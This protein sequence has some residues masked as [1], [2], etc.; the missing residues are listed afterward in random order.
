MQPAKP[1]GVEDGILI[2]L[3]KFQSVEKPQAQILGSGAI[4]PEAV[5]AAEL[6]SEKYR[7]EANVWSVTSYKNLIEDG[8]DAERTVVRNGKKAK[9]WVTE[10][11][12]KE[13]GPV[14][15]AYDY[16]KILP[17]SISKWVPGGIVSLGTDRFGRR[18]GRDALRDHFEVNANAI[19]WT[20]L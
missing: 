17:T 6:L 12:E 8:L 16:M 14:I 1:E 18:D 4:L 2:G 13:D 3:Y 15:A 20:D 7:V 19:T 10:C 11:L 9:A 5:L